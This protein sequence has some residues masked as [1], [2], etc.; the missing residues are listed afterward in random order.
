MNTLNEKISSYNFKVLM[1]ILL[2]KAKRLKDKFRLS[3]YIKYNKKYLS[4]ILVLR[5]ILSLLIFTNY[6]YF[7]N[8]TKIR[9]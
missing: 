4:L 7:K 1:Y 6:I 5:N 3:F 8:N 9:L 2:K